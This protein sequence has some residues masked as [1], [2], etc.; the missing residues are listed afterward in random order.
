M[1][2]ATV[3]AI[4]LESYTNTALGY[5]G[6][7]NVKFGVQIRQLR[8]EHPDIHYV[9]ALLQYVRNFAVQFRD[10][11]MLVSVD[12]KAIIPVGEPSCHVSTGVRGHN[13]SLVPHS[14]PQLEALDHDFHVHG[15]V[16]SVS[17]FIDIPENASDSL[18]RSHPFVTN[19]DKVS[20]PSLSGR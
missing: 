2:T 13:H 3:L 1:D 9:S 15:I 17:F 10:H 4:K 5:T 18:Y 12:D 19:I 20:Q 7:F 14:G 11:L 6:R 8:K 16:P